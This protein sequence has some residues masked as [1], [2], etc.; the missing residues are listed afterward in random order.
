MI[1][2]NKR[3]HIPEEFVQGKTKDEFK[4]F[5]LPMLYREDFE[6]VWDKCKK[7]AQVKTFEEKLEDREKK[8][9]KPLSTKSK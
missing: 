1:V 7:F 5:I 2:I 8:I 9:P 6:E 4:K 3:L